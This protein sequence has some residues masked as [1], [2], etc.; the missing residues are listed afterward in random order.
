MH[1]LLEECLQ[2]QGLVLC[3]LFFSNN[4]IQDYKNLWHGCFK[5]KSCFLRSTKETFS[6]SINSLLS[7]KCIRRLKD[8]RREH[9]LLSI[10]ACLTAPAKCHHIFAMSSRAPV[11]LWAAPFLLIAGCHLTITVE[12][13]TGQPNRWPL[14]ERTNLSVWCP[15][16][17]W[18]STRSSPRLPVMA[19]L[20]GRRH[21]SAAFS[22]PRTVELVVHESTVCSYD[23]SLSETADSND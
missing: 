17:K 20:Q 5:R 6:C 18:A 11:P 2:G 9:L 7:S 1:K 4:R 14:V 3:I 13:I 12:I 16:I 23:T 22:L 19:S 15:N 8:A 21:V 10:S